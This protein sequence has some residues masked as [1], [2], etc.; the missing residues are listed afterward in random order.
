V[1][2]SKNFPLASVYLVLLTL[3]GFAPAARLAAQDSA[4]PSPFNLSGELGEDGLGLPRLPGFESDE[5]SNVAFTAKYLFDKEAGQA[6]LSVTSAVAEGWHVYSLTQGKRN[7]AGPQA[8]KIAV[9]S[10]ALADPA[11]SDAKNTT[12]FFKSESDP[13]RHIDKK[14]WPGLEIEEHVG[15]VTW[16]AMVPLAAGV[17]PEKAEFAVTVSGQ[18]CQTDGQCIQFKETIDTKFGGYLEPPTKDGRFESSNVVIEA[19]AEPASAN[20]GE[21]LKLVIT[22][23]PSPG[24]HLYERNDRDP[25]HSDGRGKPTLIVLSKLDGLLLHSITPSSGV[26]VK[27]ADSVVGE[28]RYHEGPVTWTVELSVPNTAGSEAKTLAGYLAYQLCDKDS[29]IAPRAARFEVPLASG[30]APPESRAP[31]RFTPASYKEASGAAKSVTYQIAEPITLQR[32]LVMLSF[33]ILGGLILNL[34]PC[35]LPVI[36]LKVLSFAEQGGQNRSRVFALNLSYSLGLIFVFL[37]LATAASFLNLSWGQ[38]FTYTWFKV[39]MVGLVFAMALSFLGV[40]EIPIPGFV[41]SGKTNELQAKEGLSGAFFKGVFT[42]ILATPCSGPF[43]GSVFGFTLGQPW[44]IT[45]LIFASVGLGM[46]LPYLII[47]VQPALVRWLPK[48]GEWMDTFKQIMGFVLLGTVVYLFTTIAEEYFIPTLAMMMGIWF[49][50]W[51]IG[52]VPAW[53]ELPAKARGWGM[54]LVATTAVTAGSFYFLA[55]WPHL[56]EWKPYSAEA[57]AKAQSEGKTVM[58]DFTASW[59]QTCQYNFFF[60][61]NTFGV[62]EV[63]QQNDVVPLLADW[64]E[65]SEEIEQKLADLKS[66]SIPLLVIYPANRPGEAIVLKDL[67]TKQQ[68]VEALEQAGPSAATDNAEVVETQAPLGKTAQAAAH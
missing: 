31:F 55:P 49:G 17:D 19:Y 32:L 18:V 41:G 13:A 15:T 43:L 53:A 52:R 63:V 37:V 46:A 59:C 54:G 1:A 21:K 61:I 57:L 8:T 65:P 7:G 10:D 33:G 36:G 9:A 20:P 12:F 68:V 56:Y 42:T 3:A 47:G 39:A 5:S 66:R 50:C 22:A 26:K 25:E 16:T 11:I 45:Y 6:K 40:W 48:P 44:Y 14:A 51:F 29:C 4:P 27:P 67:L 28:Q 2:Y 24:W 35:V 64:S 30:T 34:M 23:T 60:A 58:V 38:Q 62:K